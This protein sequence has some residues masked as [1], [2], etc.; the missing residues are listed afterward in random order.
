MMEVKLAKMRDTD[1]V[2]NVFIRKLAVGAVQE[3]TINKA[4]TMEVQDQ[5]KTI[6]ELK[7]KLMSLNAS[8][9]RT[10]K[11]FE[12]CKEQRYMK[13]K[14]GRR[15]NVEMVLPKYIGMVHEMRKNLTFHVALVV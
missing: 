2:S 6:S 9:V 3:S 4:L 8:K 10:E 14:D 5:K 1:N 11:K 13:T 15:R 7:M 12:G